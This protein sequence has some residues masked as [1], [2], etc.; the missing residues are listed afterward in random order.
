M[1][2]LYVEDDALVRRTVERALQWAWRDVRITAT[3]TF[4]EA[5][6]A[7]DDARPDV[8]VTDLR[9]P[10]DL[11][12]LHGLDLVARAR[13]DETRTLVLT[14]L[15]PEAREEAHRAGAQIAL[16]KPVCIQTLRD[17]G[18]QLGIR[19]L[20][21]DRAD[22]LASKLGGSSRA[23]RDARAAIRLAAEDDGPV[24]FLGDT[25]TGKGV[26]ARALHDLRCPG[27]PFEH[28]NC[29]ALPEHLIENELLGHV[30][31]AFTGARDRYAGAFE[32]AHGGTLFLDEVAELP[33]PLQPK[34]LTLLDGSEYHPLGAARSLRP[35][36]RIVFA[37]NRDLE[38]LVA[39]GALREDLF[40]RILSAWTIRLPA[41][42]DRQEDV[43]E[44]VEA[45]LK[46]KG[47]AKYLA[48]D[49]VSLLVAGDW[50]GNV[51]Q[52]ATVVDRIAHYLPRDR[53]DAADLVGF[54]VPRMMTLG[55]A[56]RRASGQTDDP[57]PAHVGMDSGSLTQRVAAVER[58]AVASALEASCGNK[59]QAAKRLG[60][61]RMA[62]ARML[63]KYKIK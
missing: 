33:L 39:S 55:H 47:S 28:V 10:P 27:R 26:A 40:W 46:A 57:H 29:G 59:T 34:L 36:A 43:P 41:L 60:I 14:G 11:G 52:L 42:A 9:L 13:R 22:P 18:S 44:L 56:I 3:G 23:M 30:R 53:V 4:P 2:V 63:S 17:A 31:G 32:R 7:Y 61:D 54:S 37:T 25:G 24:L 45:M 38:Q 21:D 49:A 6:R 50:P 51:R 5:L 1:D 20:E 58:Q 48:P 12:K 8:L 62:L 19:V 35:G 16:D 15:G